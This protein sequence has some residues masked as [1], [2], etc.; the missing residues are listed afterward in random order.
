MLFTAITILVAGELASG[1]QPEFVA[2]MAGTIT[3]IAVTF[4]LLGGLRTIAGIG[5][6][7]FA[8]CTIV[9]SQFAKV[10]FFEAADKNLEAP[11]LTIKVYLVF[12][13]CLMLGV[14]VYGRLRINLL[15]PLE[16]ESAAQIELQYAASLVVGLIANGLYTYYDSQAASGGEATEGHS[17][18]VA[19]SV[20]LL[21]SLVLAVLTRIRE[22]GGRH[23]FGI[24][25]FI[26]W[27]V[28]VGMG[29]IRTSRGSVLLPSIIYLVTCY[30]SGY[31]F[32]K[33]HYFV[34][35]TGLILFVA[36]ISPLEI[37][38]R[39]NLVGG[40]LSS[41]I[42]NATVLIRTR[43][44]WEVIRQ[45]STG[46][47]QSGSREEYY[48]R[49]G[50]FELSRISAIRA[51]SNMINATS[52]GFHYGFTA[53]KIDV[54]HSVPHFLYPDKPQE[55][56][57]WYLGRVT[58]VNTDNVENG[59]VMITAISDSYGAFGWLGVVVVGGLV[60]PGC[61]VLYESLFDLKR[62]WGVVALSSFAYSLTEISMGGM[63]QVLT[64]APLAIVALSYVVG[65]IV[66]MIPVKGDQG[67]QMS[68]TSTSGDLEAIG[69]CAFSSS[70][71]LITGIRLGHRKEAFH[72]ESCGSVQLC[73]EN[74]IRARLFPPAVLAFFTF[75][76]VILFRRS[77]LFRRWSSA[78]SLSF[79]RGC[80]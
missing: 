59:E 36:F 41:R 64:R 13:L 58:G 57:D 78:R 6:T 14:F 70:G 8:L 76:A 1:T 80:T 17:V 31:R 35:V 26:P 15:K 30:T 29:L 67:I 65:A 44:S 56:S 50:T 66:S 27:I 63:V 11:N 71:G 51:D 69:K 75:V 16:P 9:I 42:A 39:M 33:K 34:G 28:M 62:P 20:L 60:F 3:C 43:P 18:G 40:D 2:M 12:Y 55:D 72:V 38:T 47:S 19:F 49:P 21:F 52:T 45:L 5:F 37:Y 79:S 48:D 32:K 23:S 7:G 74:I 10:V 46:G 24:K 77:R 61:F 54:L 68:G 22:T 25:A 4:N 53:L 73:R